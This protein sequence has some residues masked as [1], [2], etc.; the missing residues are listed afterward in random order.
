MPL[1]E[2]HAY[3]SFLLLGNRHQ[4]LCEFPIFKYLQ[5]LKKLMVIL[6]LLQ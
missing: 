6:F 4:H 1:L 5:G 3:V 2:D